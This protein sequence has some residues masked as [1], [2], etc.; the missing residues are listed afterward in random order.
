MVDI[1]DSQTRSRM[2][3]GIRAENTRPEIMVRKWLHRS[4]FRFRLHRKDLPGNPD[5]V[6]PKY[7]AV[8]LVHGCFWHR[9]QNC[10]LAYMPKSNEAFWRKKFTQNVHRD[11]RNIEKLISLGWRVF[12]VWE[13]ETRIPFSFERRMNQ[14]ATSLN[15]ENNPK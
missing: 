6:L 14:I 7:R 13:C 3:R 10:R 5:I 11:H 2:M 1:V 8:I 4:G 15:A 12:V 9:H